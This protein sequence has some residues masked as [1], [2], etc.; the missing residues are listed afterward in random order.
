MLSVSRPIEVWGGR[1]ADAWM[2]AQRLS[3]QDWLELDQ[4][5]A[6]AVMVSNDL[7]VSIVPDWALP[8]PEGVR[9]ARLPLPGEVPPREIGLL[10]RRGSATGRLAALLLDALRRAK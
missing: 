4:L 2:K 1:L 3:P 9:V 10:W 6:I 8:W 5:E 7:G